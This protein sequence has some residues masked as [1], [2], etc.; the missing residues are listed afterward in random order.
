MKALALE[1]A[2]NGAKAPV[3]GLFR[4]VVGLLFASHG[5]ATLFGV[6]GGAYG[7]PPEAG[8]WPGWWAAVIQL[9]G[10]ALVL[11]GLATRWSA[12]AC[13]GSMAYAYF[14]RH[15][16][17]GLF[18]LENGGEAAAMFSWAFLLIAVQGPGRWAVESLFSRAPQRRAAG[19]AASPVR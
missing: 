6:P 11:C 12:V 2:L 19:E 3:L 4:V 16:P 15:Q 7:A 14:V 18:P 1:G 8:A 5:A 10:G 9:V 17:E 13:S